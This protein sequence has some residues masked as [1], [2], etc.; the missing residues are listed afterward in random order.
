MHGYTVYVFTLDLYFIGGM[1]LTCTAFPKRKSDLIILRI[2]LRDVLIY[3]YYYHVC[4]IYS[5]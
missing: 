3:R 4:C 2:A 1:G 5:S